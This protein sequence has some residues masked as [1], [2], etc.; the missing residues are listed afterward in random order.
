MK[1]INDYVV[2]PYITREII[3]KNLGLTDEQ[4]DTALADL[5]KMN[6]ITIDEEGRIYD[7]V[8]SFNRA[9]EQWQNS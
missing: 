6:I 2:L 9:A 4:V 5:Q 3:Q 1:K 7:V 8:E